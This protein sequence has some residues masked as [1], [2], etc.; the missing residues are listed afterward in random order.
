MAHEP[1]RAVVQAEA[2]ELHEVASHSEGLARMGGEGSQA[3]ASPLPREG[4]LSDGRLGKPPAALEDGAP[5]LA[6]GR[7]DKEG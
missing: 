5:L 3:L 7:G 1:A 6:A 2:S 4:P